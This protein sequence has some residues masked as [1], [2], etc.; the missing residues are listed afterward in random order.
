MDDTY[1]ADSA[2]DIDVVDD[3][4]TRSIVQKSCRDVYALARDLSHDIMSPVVD[5]IYSPSSI[6]HRVCRT[7]YST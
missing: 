7:E 3:G 1:T 2:T 4:S 6:T 5:H